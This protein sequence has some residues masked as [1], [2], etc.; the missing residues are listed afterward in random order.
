MDW[1]MGHSELD[2]FM[3]NYIGRKVSTYSTVEEREKKLTYLKGQHTHTV[4]LKTTWRTR[5]CWGGAGYSSASTRRAA[6][7]TEA[8]RLRRWGDLLVLSA[9]RDPV[10][11]MW[12]VMCCISIYYNFFFSMVLDIYFYCAVPLRAWH[13]LQCKDLHDE[14]NFFS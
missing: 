3:L 11:V 9:W 12:A 2:T 13:L 6:V 7:T 5:Q 4:S 8:A 1:Q 10:E 14:T